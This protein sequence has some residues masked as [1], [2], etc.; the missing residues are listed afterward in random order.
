MKNVEELTR[1]LSDYATKADVT[2]VR[3]EL[4]I[5]KETAKR[6]SARSKVC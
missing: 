6:Q 4:K 2:S 1:R 5:V 3:D